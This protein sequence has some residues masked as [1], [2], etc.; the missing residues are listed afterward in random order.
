[1]II[2]GIDGRVHSI[3]LEEHIIG[4]M[5]WIWLSSIALLVGA[6]LDAALTGVQKQPDT[7]EC[8]AQV[9]HHPNWH[10]QRAEVGQIPRP[11]EGHP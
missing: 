4:F 6:E 5:V 2:F 3:V 9:P 1:M 11:F 10:L 8:P 7:A